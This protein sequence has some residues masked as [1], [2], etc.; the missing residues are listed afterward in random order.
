MLIAWASAATLP[1]LMAINILAAQHALLGATAWLSVL[2][3]AVA[4]LSSATI[5]TITLIDRSAGIDLPPGTVT[6]L[7]A[8]G[9]TT[10]SAPAPA[11]AQA[12]AQGQG[13]VT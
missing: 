3:T 6:L 11:Q 8:P 7:P 9:A 5:F 10:Q 2:A 13:P 4:S 1:P 12:Q